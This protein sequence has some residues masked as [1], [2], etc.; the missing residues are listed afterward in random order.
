M[1]E[2][3][4][5]SYRELIE[6]AGV[7]RGALKETTDHAIRGN[8]LQCVQAGC[9][10]QP[11]AK[12]E[13][14]VFELKWYEADYTT[15]LARFRGFFAGAGNRTYVPDEFFTRILPSVSLSV[16][17]VVGAVIR[18]STGFEVKRGFRRQQAA[19]SYRDIQRYCKIASPQDLSK[20]IQ[21]AL[22]AGPLF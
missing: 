2:Q 20:A 7:S 19:L 8:L 4:R 13:S 21:Y 10:S 18:F 22:E 3:H 12:A 16:L 9:A 1:S 6:K 17:K 14:S 11:G 5:V 15:N